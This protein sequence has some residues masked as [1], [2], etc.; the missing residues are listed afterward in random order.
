MNIEQLIKYIR[1]N[2]GEKKNS[3]AINL[4]AAM[5]FGSWAKSIPLQGIF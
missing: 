5:L 2:L 4:R 1:K 3:L